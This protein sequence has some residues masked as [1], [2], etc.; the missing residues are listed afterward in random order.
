MKEITEKYPKAWKS[1]WTWYFDR[2]YNGSS[3]ECERYLRN[4]ELNYLFGYLVLEFFPEHGIEI[5][6]TYYHV[7]KLVVY[8]CFNKK[9]ESGETFDTPQEVIEKAFEI[10]EAKLKEG[11]L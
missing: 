8:Y 11:E 3:K 10:L 2:D 9:I 7:N 1:F 5:E 4:L 6:R